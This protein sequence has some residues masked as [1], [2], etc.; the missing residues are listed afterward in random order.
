[1][2]NNTILKQLS[3][4]P[5]ILAFVLLGCDGGSKHLEQAKEAVSQGI[6]SLGKAVDEYT[7]ESVKSSARQVPI[8]A[9]DEYEKIFRIDYR[10]I[11]LPRGKGPQ[12]F[13]AALNELGKERWECFH[14]EPQAE[15]LI[16]FCSRRPLSYIRYLRHLVGLF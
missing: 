1:M 5:L 2:F 14:I 6:N 15:K 16:A 12:Y 10:V 7:P 4:T 13:E 9:E 3:L 8:M 11:E